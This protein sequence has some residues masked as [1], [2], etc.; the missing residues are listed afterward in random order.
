[1]KHSKSQ[2]HDAAGAAAAS[3]WI[4]YTEELLEIIIHPQMK[5]VLL[6]NV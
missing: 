3:G 2:C 6:S 5:S 1:M 4:T